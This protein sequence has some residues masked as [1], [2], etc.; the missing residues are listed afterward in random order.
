MRQH[1]NLSWGQLSFWDKAKLY[2][3]FCFVAIAGNIFQITGSVLYFLRPIREVQFGEVMIGFGCLF[4]WCTL[5]RYFMYSQRYSLALRTLEF[6]FPVLMRAVLGIIPFFIGYAILGQCLFWEAYSKFGTFSTSLM[7]LFCMMNGDNLVPIH[8]ALSTID[9]L[10]GNLYC[11]TYIF[12][13][14]V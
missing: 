11:Y 1:Q 14:I 10:L 12:L 5:P 2:N 9:V 7:C 4:A 3:K 6:S 8:D 13:S